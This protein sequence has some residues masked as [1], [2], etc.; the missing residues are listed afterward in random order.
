MTHVMKQILW[1]LAMMVVLAPW[2][3]AQEKA[4]G[5]NE[6]LRQ[7]AHP[8]GFWVG[9]TIQGRMWN[10]DPAY[11]PVMGR[12]FNAGVSIVFSGI[13]QPQRG[14]F[15]FDPMDEAMSF[16]KQHHMKLM[17]HCRV[18]PKN[19]DSRAVDQL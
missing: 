14:H 2:T 4:V 8:M 18:D 3:T 13:T 10:H 17:G 12:E 15:D 5:G 6:S 7:A 9:T 19:A 1:I 11:K 16:A